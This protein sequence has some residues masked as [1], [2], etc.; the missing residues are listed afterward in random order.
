MPEENQSSELMSKYQ[1]VTIV[2]ALVRLGDRLL[3]V[4][5]DNKTWFLPGGELDSDDDLLKCVEQQVLYTAGL[6]INPGR[7]FSIYETFDEDSK[8]HTIE[9]VFFSRFKEDNIGEVQDGLTLTMPYHQFFTLDQ[10]VKN[11]NIFPRFLE[12]GNWLTPNKS[13]IMA[14]YQGVV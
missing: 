2:R 6:L 9:N 7:L 14:L 10:I 13:N 4:S 3:F 11:E 1:L 8:I 5:N 12:F